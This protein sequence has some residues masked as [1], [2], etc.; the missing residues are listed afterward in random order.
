MEEMQIVEKNRQM[1]RR[2]L[3][4]LFVMVLC[5]FH[6]L[7]QTT[8]DTTKTVRIIVDEEQ[9][10]IFVDSLR[11]RILSDAVKFDPEDLQHFNNRTENQN[12]YSMLMSVNNV[13]WY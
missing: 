1:N 7:E 4:L 13:Y 6:A 5:S 12:P 11:E 10:R 2:I 8:K 3:F 9:V